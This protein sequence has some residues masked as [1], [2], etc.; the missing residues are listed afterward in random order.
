MMPSGPRHAKV[1]PIPKTAGA[2][3]QS[4]KLPTSSEERRHDLTV[5]K[6]KVLAT[7]PLAL[8]QFMS[9]RIIMQQ[10][11]R[12]WIKTSCSCMPTQCWW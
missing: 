4:N 2:K 12:R 7:C 1:L 9:T 5:N 6:F 3:P 10:H 11:A 8:A